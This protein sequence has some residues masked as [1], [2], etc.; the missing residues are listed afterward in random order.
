M[1]RTYRRKNYEAENRTSWDTR[2]DKVAGFYTVRDLIRY[3]SIKS[4]YY[5]YSHQYEYKVPTK[6]EYN[7][8]YWDYHSDRQSRH[9]RKGPAKW[10]RIFKIHQYR[11][12]DKTELRKFMK[13]TDYE[14]MCRD[15]ISSGYW[16]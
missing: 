4:D 15:R 5:H 8:K 6:F 16:D 10:Y 11:M 1:S 2:G 13:D 9:V 7:K 12:Q 3:M 14:P